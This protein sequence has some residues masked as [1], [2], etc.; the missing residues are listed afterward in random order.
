MVLTSS[1]EY[2]KVRASWWLET[3]VESSQNLMV[4]RALRREKRQKVRREEREI[5]DIEKR[6]ECGM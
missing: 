5:W 2:P 6:E 4:V 1:V 3:V